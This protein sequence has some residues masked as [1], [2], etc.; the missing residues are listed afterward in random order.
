[1]HLRSLR[2]YSFVS[3]SR[4][5]AIAWRVAGLNPSLQ[6]CGGRTSLARERSLG[7]HRAIWVFESGGGNVVAAHRPRYVAK[8]IG[9]ATG[10]FVD[11][12]WFANTLV[13]VKEKFGGYHLTQDRVLLALNGSYPSRTGHRAA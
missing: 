4:I 10:Q 7:R 3:S 13:I 8:G 1:M 5:L 9:L 2:R 12:D 11:W 6:S